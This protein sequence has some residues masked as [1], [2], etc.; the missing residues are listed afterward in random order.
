MG[1]K[2]KALLIG[3][4]Y[5]N[6]QYQLSGCCDD[7]RT[8]KEFLE[9]NGFDEAADILVLT[10]D[11]PDVNFHPTK[12]NIINGLQWL[13]TDVQPDDSLFLTYSGM[14]PGEQDLSSTAPDA[15]VKALCPMDFSLYG[16]I[17]EDEAYDIVVRN[18]PKPCAFNAVFDCANTLFDM[19]MGWMYAASA[20]GGGIS[21]A[22]LKVQAGLGPRQAFKL[23][24][25]NQEA[26]LCVIACSYDRTMAKERA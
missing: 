20:V 25:A 10:D 17:S 26:N 21:G 3:I 2:S 13:V 16:T 5:L 14:A 9:K 8:M 24:R 6:T 4:D 22:P 15:I 12:A 1:M 7:A 18:I 11:N 19:G 23:E